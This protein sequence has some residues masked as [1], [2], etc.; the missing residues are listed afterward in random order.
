MSTFTENVLKKSSILFMVPLVG[1]RS[2]MH[3][4]TS[5]LLSLEEAVLTLDSIPGKEIKEELRMILSD[6]PQSNSAWGKHCL[7]NTNMAIILDSRKV[8]SPVM[9]KTYAQK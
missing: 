5:G 1:K 7:T 9:L 2:G 3:T 8:T 6:C 4:D